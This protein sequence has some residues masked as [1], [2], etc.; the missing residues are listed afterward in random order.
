MKQQELELNEYKERVGS[1]EVPKV[2]YTAKVLELRKNLT[3][4]I[5]V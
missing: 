2:K 5:Q 3:S 4:L 1:E